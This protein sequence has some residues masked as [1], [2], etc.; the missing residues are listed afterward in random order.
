MLYCYASLDSI[1]VF[2]FLTISIDMY[3]PVTLELKSPAMRILYTLMFAAIRERPQLQG[4]ALK[5][6][7][8]RGAHQLMVNHSY[9][10]LQTYVVL[11]RL[12]IKQS[13]GQDVPSSSESNG[14]SDA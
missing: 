2:F 12:S 1:T 5:A 9:F 10:V 6:P 8:S 14:S 4:W 7:S 13:L 3:C 11:G